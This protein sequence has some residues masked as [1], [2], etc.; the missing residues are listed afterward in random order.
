M[1]K[2]GPLRQRDVKALRLDCHISNTKAFLHGPQKGSIRTLEMF[3][4]PELYRHV[5][6]S[7][8]RGTYVLLS[9]FV[10]LPGC[11]AYISSGQNSS[12]LSR[13]TALKRQDCK[14]FFEVA[15]LILRADVLWTLICTNRGLKFGIIV[16]VFYFIFLCFWKKYLT[17]NKTVCIYVFYFMY[18]IH[19]FF[20]FVFFNGDVLVFLM[21]GWIYRSIQYLCFVSVLF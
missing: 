20:W 19:M 15:Y 18:Y 17:L 7:Q 5:M 11:A 13:K 14:H 21:D 1:H 2:K 10:T 6:D 3:Q 9:V 4:T 8:T 16:I 12:E